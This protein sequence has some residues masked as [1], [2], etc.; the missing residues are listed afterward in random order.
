MQIIMTERTQNYKDLEVMVEFFEQKLGCATFEVLHANLFGKYLLT[1]N[2]L[3]YLS[4][5]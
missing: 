4:R 1:M 5:V 3:K 2:E